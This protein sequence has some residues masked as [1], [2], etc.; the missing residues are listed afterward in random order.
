MVRVSSQEYSRE[1]YLKNKEKKAAQEK[2]RRLANPLYKRQVHLK[3][4]YNLT[5]EQFDQMLKSQNNQCLICEEILKPTSHGRHIDHCHTTGKVRGILCQRCNTG[6]GK[7]EENVN[8]L[9]KAIAYIEV[10][11]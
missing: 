5:L 7:F 9:K 4:R 6:I 2:A 11:Q 10:H 8:L 1:W 3:N